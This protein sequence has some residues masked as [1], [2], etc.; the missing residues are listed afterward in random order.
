MKKNTSHVTKNPTEKNRYQ[1]AISKTTTEP[2][3]KDSIDFGEGTNNTEDEIQAKPNAKRSL[4]LMEIVQNTITQYWIQ[5]GLGILFIVII[6]LFYDSKS[7]L[8]SIEK[9]I[10]IQQQQLNLLSKAIDQ[11][12]DE[13]QRY[14]QEIQNTL[15]AMREKVDDVNEKNNAQDLLISEIKIKIDLIF[16]E[17]NK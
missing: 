17:S 13:S 11:N 2:T 16:H 6:Y 4:P 7:T 10:E 15:S 9:D 5:G 12:D 8:Y 14:I 1:R 3:L